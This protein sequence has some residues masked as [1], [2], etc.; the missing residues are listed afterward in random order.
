MP[1]TG[2]PRCGEGVAQAGGRI[3]RGGRLATDA[4]V[5][6]PLVRLLFRLRQPHT[7]VSEQPRPQGGAL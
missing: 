2:P 7:P 4:G 5:S 3:A 6:G 1:T